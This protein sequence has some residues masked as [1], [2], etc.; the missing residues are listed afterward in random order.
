MQDAE[1][2]RNFSKTLIFLSAAVAGAL[3]LRIFF[4][5][6][7]AMPLPD[8]AYYVRSALD[9]LQ[10]RNFGDF[11]QPVS[12]GQPLFSAMLAVL[13][14]LFPGPLFSA[15]V[16]S[17]LAGSLTV[18]PLYFATRRIAGERAARMSSVLCA[19]APFAI[20]YSLWAMPHALFNFFWISLMAC[21]GEALWTGSKRWAA[22]AALS[23][24]GGYMMRVEN[25]IFFGGLYL[26][27]LA[28]YARRRSS[29]RFSVGVVM[30]A[31][32]LAACIPFWIFLH[33]KTGEWSLTWM[34][35]RS[36][37]QDLLTT[38]LKVNKPGFSLSGLF[39]I[40][41]L[42]WIEAARDC[43][44]VFSFSWLGLAAAGLIS[45]LKKTLRSSQGA[46]VALP[47][48][49]IPFFFYPFFGTDTRYF[50]PAMLP[51]TIYS[52]LGALWPKLR[53]GRIFCVL[54]LAAGLLLGYRGLWLANRDDR[55][56]LRQAGIWLQKNA[57]AGSVLFGG[58]TRVCLYAGAA[59]GRFVTL[60]RHKNLF[61][62][63]VPFAEFVKSAGVEWVIDDPE[64]LQSYYPDIQARL[65]SEVRQ[66]P[67]ESRHEAGSLTL[68]HVRPNLAPEGKR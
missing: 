37:W 54:L 33:E 11:L 40:Y 65:R 12:R 17:I 68:Y 66:A 18:V 53:P 36:A 30:P 4:W 34:S 14:P 42:R 49:L 47:F 32:F 15:Q 3:M 61:A 23:A 25:I 16:M 28:F 1:I 31:V 52:G 48:I 19:A 67:F 62:S 63:G 24:W 46:G 26:F 20:Q 21:L 13:T 5:T 44:K 43:A 9:I 51:L 29:A 50:H 2:K 39:R 60:Q 10:Y 27:F 7:A 8:E 57:A 64:L 41:G 22:A 59:C 6:R 56:A 45:S 38:H 58:D 35:G 55:P